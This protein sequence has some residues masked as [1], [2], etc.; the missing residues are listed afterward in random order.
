MSR[1]EHAGRGHGLHLLAEMAALLALVTLAG[2]FI[3]TLRPGAEQRL[4]LSQALSWAGGG[5]VVLSILLFAL[6]GQKPGDGLFRRIRRGVFRLTLLGAILLTCLVGG[7]VFLRWRAG[8]R[9]GG[10]ALA[11]QTQATSNP[12]YFELDKAKIWNRRFY[13]ARRDY[14]ENWPIPLDFFESDKPTPRN[15][16]KPGQSWTFKGNTLQKAGAGEHVDRAYNSWGFRGADFAVTRQPGTLRIVCLGGSV[17]EGI[18]AEDAT[19]P[20]A[21][22]KQLQERFPGCLVEVINAGHQGQGVDDLLEIWRQRVRPLNP[23]LVLFYEGSNDIY[24]RD[25]YTVPE[26]VAST[27]PRRTARLVQRSFLLR[28]IRDR[29]GEPNPLENAPP[30]TFNDSG[31]KPSA[32]H[33]KTGLT[34]LCQEIQQSGAQMVLTS[35]VT[36]AHPGLELQRSDNPAVYDFLHTTL[37]PLSAD[38]I[39]RVYATVNRCSAEVAKSN[40]VPYLD[41]AAVFPRELKYFPFDLIHLNRDGNQTLARLFAEGLQREVLEQ[42]GKSLRIRPDVRMMGL[43]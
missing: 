5:L 4:V 20:V 39:G 6:R 43:R 31:T 32:Q 8:W 33:Y 1:K 10:T 3:N 29:M 7:E 35:F 19:F 11:Q 28:M 34:Q 12:Y 30:H 26:G 42:Q 2:W 22:A 21:L 15:L 36:L 41:V 40:H 38:E 24:L 27:K 14:F 16:Y 18:C 25:Y 17:T 23:D 9:P 37:A 13:A